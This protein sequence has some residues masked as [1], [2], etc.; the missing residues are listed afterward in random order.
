MN[1][2]ISSSWKNKASVRWLAEQ[3]RCLGHE[4]YDF[5]DPSCRKTEEIPPEKFPDQY[6]PSKHCY[7]EYIQRPE[8]ALAVEENRQALDRCDVVILLLPCGNDAHADWAYAVGKGKHTYVAG[9]PKKGERSPVHLWADRMFPN[10][11][12]FL[13]FIEEW[14]R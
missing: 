14:G 8:W 11:D 9:C 13:Q 2:Y 7:V 3:L 1:I 12:M 4:V 10:E 5:T 6:D